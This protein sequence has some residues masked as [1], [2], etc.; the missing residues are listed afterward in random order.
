MT[1]SPARK[2][3]PGWLG[4]G[5]ATGLFSAAKESTTV[6]SNTTPMVQRLESFMNGLAQAW[7]NVLLHKP[8]SR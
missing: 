8:I 1:S 2:T 3:L 4:K 6:A 5:R 7:D